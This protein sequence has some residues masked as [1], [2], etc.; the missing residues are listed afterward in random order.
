VFFGPHHVVL[1]V[2]LHRSRYVPRVLS[3]FVIAAGIGYVVDSLASLLVD[4]HG[5]PQS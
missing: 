2:G 4:G 5:G 3:W 1:G